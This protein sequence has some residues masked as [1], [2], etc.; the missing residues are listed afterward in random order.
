M[1]L[2]GFGFMDLGLTCKY[3]E[4]LRSKTVGGVELRQL[5]ESENLIEPRI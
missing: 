3:T 2:W 5:Y 1:L 4:E